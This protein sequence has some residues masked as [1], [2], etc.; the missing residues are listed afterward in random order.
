MEIIVI[1]FIILQHCNHKRFTIRT[2]SQH[3]SYTFTLLS[4][5]TTKQQRPQKWVSFVILCVTLQFPNRAGLCAYEH[6]QG[7]NNI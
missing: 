3:S 4:H 7:Q 2:G 1:N 5:P 6:L